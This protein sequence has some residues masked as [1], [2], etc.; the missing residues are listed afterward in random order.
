MI[1][2]VYEIENRSHHVFNDNIIESQNEWHRKKQIS[3]KIMII[4]IACNMN[5][6]CLVPSAIQKF[7]DLKNYE[8][9]FS[10]FS[11]LILALNRN[12]VD[13]KVIKQLRI[14]CVRISPIKSG[15]LSLYPLSTCALAFASFQSDGSS[16]VMMQ[17]HANQKSNGID[18]I[19]HKHAHTPCHLSADG[20][21]LSIETIVVQIVMSP[22]KNIWHCTL[23][24]YDVADS[25]YS[26]RWSR[27]VDVKVNQFSYKWNHN[28]CFNAIYHHQFHQLSVDYLF[29]PLNLLGVVSA[30]PWWSMIDGPKLMIHPYR[31]NNNQWWVHRADDRIIR[32][33]IDYYYY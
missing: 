6:P 27:F 17:K 7:Y 30:D 11:S 31:W 13:W 4:M 1:R 12:W 15:N 18:Q 23:I 29:A 20:F 19:R 2:F 22:T 14:T 21:I 9:F 28:W 16:S 26:I 10:F 33:F 25:Q 24:L 8:V 32:F 5:V 3:W